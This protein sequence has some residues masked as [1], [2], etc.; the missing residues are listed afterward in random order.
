MSTSFIQVWDEKSKTL[1]TI[2]LMRNFNEGHV[3]STCSHTGTIGD[4]KGGGSATDLS[5]LM[6]EIRELRS[7]VGGLEETLATLAPSA[8][9]GLTLDT[10][11]ARVRRLELVVQNAFNL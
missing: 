9:E 6:T 8:A 3:H 7:R 10:L 1:R 11:D 5:L 4:N 2:P